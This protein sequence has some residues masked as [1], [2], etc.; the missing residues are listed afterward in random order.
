M[1]PAFIHKNEPL[2]VDLPYLLAPAPSLL[3]VALRS[4]ERL[5]LSGRPS[6]SNAR[7]M[8]AAETE[9]P[10]VSSNSW[11]CSSRVKSELA[12]RAGKAELPPKPCLFWQEDR[13]SV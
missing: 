13:G 5:F 6:R 9:M 1:G 2:W 11:R 10:Y 3:F 4:T 12:L 7:L 8:L